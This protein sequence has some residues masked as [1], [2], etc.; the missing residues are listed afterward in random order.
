[1]MEGVETV[2]GGTGA[3]AEQDS[4][5]FE[6]ILTWPNAVSV[7]R[8]ACLPV[9][10]WLLFGLENRLAAA[11]LLAAL[12][13]TDWVDGW[14][15]RV[16]DQTSNVGKMLDPVADR[17]LFFVGVGGILA[18]GSVPVWFAVVV[19][20]REALVGGA[21]VLL[22]VLGARRM[23]V[24]WAGKAGTFGLMFTFP[25]FL[26]GHA[27]ISGAWVFELLGWLSGIPALALSLYAAVMYI[28]AARRAL[29]EGRAEGSD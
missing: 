29:A 28:P 13:A 16:L 8:L 11:G 18:D 12:G 14:L 15:A 26:A 9:F 10:L 25:F 19:L 17:F 24:S 1:M 21:T 3:A 7:G 27:D 23:D 5:G 2:A 6:R 20:A 22:A 4:S